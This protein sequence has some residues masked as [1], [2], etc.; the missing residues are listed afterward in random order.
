MLGGG[1]LL[2][3]FNSL[4]HTVDVEP[5]DKSYIK[6]QLNIVLGFISNAHYANYQPLLQTNLFWGQPVSVWACGDDCAM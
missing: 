1:A 4:Q 2:F 6:L 3:F 5:T